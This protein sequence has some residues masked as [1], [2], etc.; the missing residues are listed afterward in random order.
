M[1]KIYLGIDIGGTKIK[2]ILLKEENLNIPRS[3]IAKKDFFLIDTPRNKK[4]FLSVLGR[5]IDLVFQK[6]KIISGIGVGLPGIV[7]SEKNILI[8]APNLPFL[9]NWKL[10]DFLKKWSGNIKTDNDS[11]CF[12]RAEAKFGAGIGFKNI[13]GIARGTGIGGGIMIEGKIYRGINNRAGEF[14]HTIID[15]N[16]TFEEAAGK[17]AFI[18]YGDR[19]D[20]IG[21]GV[22]NLINIFDP[23]LIILGGGG[24]TCGAVKMDIVKNIAKKYIISQTAKKTK[25]VKTKLGDK[26]GSIG[27]AALFLDY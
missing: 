6:N 8:K 21:I 25:I 23:E 3:L 7:D 9:K 5:F 19:S 20:M 14:G 26:A 27:A 18:N 17:A 15:N 12:L 24:V 22:A 4:N 13:I 10:Q 2:A 16:K 1:S 11:R